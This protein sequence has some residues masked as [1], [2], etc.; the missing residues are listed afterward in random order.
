MRGIFHFTGQVLPGEVE[1]FMQ[2]QPPLWAVGH[3]IYDA[4]MGDPHAGAAFAGVAL[5][6][7]KGN[8]LFRDNDGL[9]VKPSGK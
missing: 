9:K 4:V 5:Q 6:F 7:A 8:D 1:K 2:T 3:I